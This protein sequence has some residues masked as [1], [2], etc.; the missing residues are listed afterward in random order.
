[1]I[2]LNSKKRKLNNIY[3]KISEQSKQYFFLKQ[4]NKD[5]YFFIDFFQINFIL[6]LW[7][8]KTKNFEDK[9][10]DYLINRYIKDLEGLVIELGGSETSLRKKIRLIIGNFYGKLYKYSDV[11]DKIVRKKNTGL[12]NIIKKDFKSL[13]DPNFLEKYIKKNISQLMKLDENEFW[14]MNFF[15]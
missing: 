10:I 13:S 2:F 5:V 6:I 12:K 15:I 1:M 3:S 8:M 9:N 11:F 14:N 7:Y 4:K